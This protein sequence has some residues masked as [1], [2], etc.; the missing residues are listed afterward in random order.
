MRGGKEK[1]WFPA[2]E[3]KNMVSFGGRKKYEFLL[4]K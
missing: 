2:E 4:L 1:I 3:G